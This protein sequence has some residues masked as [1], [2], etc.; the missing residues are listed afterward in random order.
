M[1]LEES[2]EGERHVLHDDDD[3][4]PNLDDYVPVF[5]PDDLVGKSFLRKGEEDDLMY[6]AHV[7][8]KL[9][10]KDAAN[11][12]QIKYRVKVGDS[13]VEELMSYVEF[14]YIIEEQIQEEVNN[15]DKLWTY[16]AIVDHSEPL[17]QNDRNYKGSRYNVK[18]Q[19]EDGSTSWEPLDI[20]R[21]DDPVTCA[22][23]AK[24]HDLLDTPGWKSLKRLVKNTKMFERAV[25]QAKMRS[26]RRASIY[27]FGVKYLV[28][29]GKL[30]NWTDRMGTQSGRMLKRRN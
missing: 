13:D 4:V 9:H 26:E 25:K 14:A 6:R 18:I 29:N 8:Q 3:P 15:P 16:K 12:H 30:G 1:E 5:N 20:V 21:K 27:M 11:H 23:Y 7:I 2:D 24:E 10:D 17:T 22:Q 19:W 28:T